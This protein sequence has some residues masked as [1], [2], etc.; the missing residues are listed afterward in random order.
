[1]WGPPTIYLSRV[2]KSS[3]NLLA[4]T[5]D[6]VFKSAPLFWDTLYIALLVLK[7]FYELNYSFLLIFESLNCWNRREKLIEV[8]YKYGT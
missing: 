1:M 7:L 2:K 8:L 6:S 4:V 3:L 5:N